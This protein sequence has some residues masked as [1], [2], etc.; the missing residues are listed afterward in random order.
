MEKTNDNYRCRTRKKIIF[1]LLII[2]EVIIGFFLILICRAAINRI[3]IYN[4]YSNTVLQG[5]NK[6]DYYVFINNG[7]SKDLYYN[8]SEKK[9]NKLLD[10]IISGNDCYI[11]YSYLPDILNDISVQ[12]CI[13][14]K[15][16]LDLYDFSLQ[17]GRGF[18]D[19]DYNYNFGN[20][21][22][23][24]VGAN[25]KD[26]YHLGGI[27]KFSNGDNGKNFNARVI[28]ILKKDTVNPTLQEVGST[29]DNSYIIPMNDYFV[30]YYFGVSDY[31][32]AMSSL[33]IKT[34]AANLENIKKIIN[35]SKMYNAQ[36]ISIKNALDNYY[37]DFIKPIINKLIYGVIFDIL[38]VI[39]ISIQ[40]IM[41]IKKH[42]KQKKII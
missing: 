16:F 5:E 7:S 23:I 33:V 31:D 15:K 4:T 20:E 17:S 39:T 11:M 38:L 29:L 9:A 2:I 27:Y 13:A 25:L 42:R 22:P 3:H 8:Y 14:N 36:F 19:S 30:N 21:V 40:I 10:N 18:N 1:I 12:K 34:D 41:I 37:N 35:N 24:L 28:G 6:E 26:V 32:M